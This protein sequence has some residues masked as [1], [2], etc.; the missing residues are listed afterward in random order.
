M[1]ANTE[2]DNGNKPQFKYFCKIF[3]ND[4]TGDYA[5]ETNVINAIQGYG[6]LEFAKK[7]V[8]HHIAKI[9]QGKIVPAKGGIMQFIRGGIK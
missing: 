4:E 6:M 7:G 2:P 9:Q 3:F 5:F 1:E 8:D